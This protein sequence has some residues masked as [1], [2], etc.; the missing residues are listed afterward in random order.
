[1]AECALALEALLG[2]Q[3]PVK[4]LRVIQSAGNTGVTAIC[5]PPGNG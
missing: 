1:V 2:R 3:L 5:K 4:M